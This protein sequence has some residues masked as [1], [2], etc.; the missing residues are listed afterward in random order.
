MRVLVLS[1]WRWPPS[2]LPIDLGTP[3][4]ASRVQHVGLKRNAVG[5]V[6]LL[7]PSALC[8]SPTLTWCRTGLTM[9]PCAVAG[10]AIASAHT[11]TRAPWFLAPLA[12]ISSKVCQGLHSPKGYARFLRI[13]MALL[14]Q[15][16]QSWELASPAWRLLGHVSHRVGG[17]P[18]L[19]SKGS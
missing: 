16:P 13:T 5:G 8:G 1:G 11:P 10:S 15:A 18:P 9:L 7:A 6:F 4:E 3:G 14:S 19:M 12:D 17:P 2:L